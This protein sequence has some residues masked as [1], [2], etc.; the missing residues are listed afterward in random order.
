MNEQSRPLADQVGE[1]M[2]GLLNDNRSI[3]TKPMKD[4]GTSQ[5]IMPI[6]ARNKQRYSGA[7]AFVLLMQNRRDP[8]WLSYD[9]ATFNKT[10]VKKGAHGV[11]IEFSSNNEFRQKT[12]N[13]QPVMKE[14]GR[15]QM[16]RVKLDEPVT[17]QAFLFNG[18]DLNNLKTGTV[19]PNA[20]TPIE[21]AETMINNSS[22]KFDYTGRVTRYDR[23]TDTIQM[24]AKETFERPELFYAAALH[25][26]AHA[27]G[28][29]T[30]LDRPIVDTPGSEQLPH[31]ELRTNIASILMSA[32]LNLPY[33]LGEHAPLTKDWAEILTNDPKELFSA[34]NDAQKIA[35]FVIGFEIEASQ[36]QDTKQAQSAKLAE[37]MEIGYNGTTYKI[38]RQ[39]SKGAFKI[40]DM[41]TSEKIKITPTNGLYKSLVNQ[42]NN[43]QPA[44]KIDERQQQDQ[45]FEIANSEEATTSHSRKR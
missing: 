23:A 11:L 14:N 24:P 17:V 12:E 8:R 25:S 22:I 41:T 37:G 4:D 43:P 28:H 16:E 44:E 10:P 38:L 31:E 6:N 2:A 13:G 35:D 32:Q 1:R 26:L 30:R 45:E 20:Q 19:K 36:K 40:E 34:A 29:E 33:D 15:P 39:Q 27:T 9:Q 7:A 3:F 42:L 21:R 5:F 18:N